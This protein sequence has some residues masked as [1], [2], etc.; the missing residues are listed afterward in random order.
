MA[1]STEFGACLGFPA[2]ADLQAQ[3]ARFGRALGVA[4]QLR[5]DL[6]G[7]WE[8]EHLGKTV[9]GDLRRKKMSL[10]VIHALHAGTSTDRST[11]RR[12][13]RKTGSL[14]EEEIGEALIILDRTGARQRIRSALVEQGSIARAALD[15]SVGG[16]EP[17]GNPAYLAL[18]ALL[19][20]VLATE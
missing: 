9:A 5:D 13:M 14:S 12:L 19:E 15:D 16:V 1:C 3:L 8:A 18:V 20:F 17:Y 2:N 10:P 11:L 6:L 4:F 7:I